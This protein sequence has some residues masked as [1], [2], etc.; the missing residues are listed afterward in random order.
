MSLTMKTSAFAK[1]RAAVML[2]CSAL[3]M[4]CSDH[5]ADEN[6]GSIE[7]PGI[8]KPLG[9]HVQD[10][11]G[12][13]IP[14][15]I[16][17]TFDRRRDVWEDE[18]HV[19]GEDPELFKDTVPHRL[20]HGT[21]PVRKYGFQ[22]I[23]SYA[24]NSSIA[25]IHKNSME[26]LAD[27]T[28]RLKTVAELATLPNAED[29]HTRHMGR[30][31][32]GWDLCP[33]KR[34][35]DQYAK[36]ALFDATCSGTLIDKNLVLTAA[37]C[38]RDQITNEIKVEL[39]DLR[40][41]FNYVVP[42][43]GT[44]ATIVAARDVFRFR[45][46]LT[47][48][49][50]LA[51]FAIL[52]LV[53]AQGNAIQSIDDA[54]VPAPLWERDQPPTPGIY[55]SGAI[56]GAGAGLPQKISLSRSFGWLTDS[57][58]LGAYMRTDTFKG[59]S[60]GGVYDVE[61]G[62]LVGIVH[63]QGEPTMQVTCPANSAQTSWPDCKLFGDQATPFQLPGESL[64]EVPEFN[65]KADGSLEFRGCMG[66]APH[67]LP[68]AIETGM[69][70]LLINRFGVADAV[71]TSAP[72]QEGLA[73]TINTVR[74]LAC[75]TVESSE[76]FDDAFRAEA[77]AIV[78]ER[79]A[80][81]G[82]CTDNTRCPTNRVVDDTLPANGALHG[83]HFALSEDAMRLLLKDSVLCTKTNPETRR[84]LWQELPKLDTEVSRESTRHGTTLAGSD[85]FD[86]STDGS[87]PVP[88]ELYRI[89]VDDYTVLYADTFSGGREL[90]S[91]NPGTNF[92][93]VL[94]VMEANDLEDDNP[95]L[96]PSA[97]QNISGAYDDSGCVPKGIPTT[98]PETIHDV[99]FLRQSQLT[100][101]LEPGKRYILGVTGFG[102]AQGD[103]N[104]H[105]QLVPSPRNGQLIRPGDAAAS[106]VAGGI[107]FDIF[108]AKP[109]V[110]TASE[111][112]CNNGMNSDEPFDP[113]CL[114][115][116]Q[117]AIRCQRTDTGEFGFVNVSCPE[118]S[119]DK[120]RFRVEGV[121]SPF[122]LHFD[123]PVAQYADGQVRHSP[124]G[125]VCS[126]D[127][128]VSVKIPGLFS[129]LI[130]S[131]ASEIGSVG[132]VRPDSAETF[133]VTGA[134]VRV[135]YAHQFQIGLNWQNL[136]FSL[137]LPQDGIND[138]WP[139]L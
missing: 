8:R 70:D 84:Q 103:F 106:V 25:F 119:T 82:Q 34:F 12:D 88:D 32:L 100:Q 26:T 74:R 92:D 101:V 66:W 127:T 28:V 3:T 136:G 20:I 78:A 137:R 60:G 104:L 4:G 54:Y 131:F 64:V 55:R 65:K 81:N 98:A 83:R 89:Q 31:A 67:E 122:G 10:E 53:D 115:S 21:R 59:N 99:G 37:H 117:P 63:A 7:Q 113:A 126:D 77:R 46:I 44:M 47:V 42:E 102:A 116:A 29:R 121:S 73:V 1:W 112:G 108:Q 68:P 5:H 45:E 107:A 96:L 135:F 94:F 18:F 120:V 111:D 125:Y 69:E 52:P 97:W 56:V 86:I 49:V 93:T 50:G 139:Q 95:L 105:V 16:S 138:P 90:G 130:P 85:Y 27:G 19:I 13:K 40:L 133:I 110:G 11:V 58:F 14:I 9:Q 23:R 30:A 57:A 38:I 15:D 91:S 39:D 35:A 87:E 61:T 132:Q 51:D 72:F 6:L 62:T 33:E 41:V 36:G 114:Y 76:P 22:W 24:R 118:F 124:T 43:R 80:F 134:G 71:V 2:L 75:K 123:D 129:A 48:H 128:K 17:A 109:F 79:G